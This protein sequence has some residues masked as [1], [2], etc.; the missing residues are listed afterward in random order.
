[1]KTKTKVLIVVIVIAALLLAGWMIYWETTHG[2]RRLIDTKNRFDYAIIALPNGDVVEGLWAA[3]A[4]TGGLY[5][6]GA[7]ARFS[8]SKALVFGARAAQGMLGEPKA[9]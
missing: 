7:M 1:M 9:G 4:M 3:G 5:G 6:D 2:N 8:F